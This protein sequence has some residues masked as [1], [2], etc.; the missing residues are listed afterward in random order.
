MD[1]ILREM[2]LLESQI[3]Y[4]AKKYYDEDAPEISDYDYDM[5]FERLKA[6]ELAY[7][8]YASLSS[9]TRRVGGHV[10]KR[11]E[12]AVHPVRMGSLADVFNDEGVLDF[13]NRVS[14]RFPETDYAVECKIDGLSVALEY[15]DGVLTK[16]VTRG[17]GFT[18]EIVT[19]NMKTIRS[20]P[21]TLK[22][23]L[24]RL[25][26]RGE[27]YMPKKV[28][29][30]LNAGREADGLSPFAN[31]RNAAAGSLRQLDSKL[32][33]ERRLSV[34]IFNVQ[35]CET[36]LPETHGET[37]KYMES[38]G[39]VVSPEFEICKNYHE[40]ADK[41]TRIGETR[42]D[43]PFEIDGAVVKVNALRLRDIM[44]DIGAVP[45][46]AVAFKYP[47][48][49]AET[50][51][52]DIVTQVGRTGVLT[53]KA[54]LKPV[55]VAG[56]VVAAATL[57]N[58]DYI[59]EKDIR[60]GDA[61]T[62]RKAGD[63]IPE[64]LRVIKEKRPADAA[65]FI[66]PESCPS[67]G[68]KVIREDGESATRCTNSACPAQLLRNIVHFVS[69]NAMDIETLGEK[70]AE[71]F[72][73]EGL[74]K[75]VADIYTLQKRQIA[76]LPGMGEKSAENLEN[77]IKSAAS[78]PLSK[79][80]YALGIRHVGEKA[81]KTLAKR[82]INI[83]DLVAAGEETLVQIDEIGPETAKS[84]V[85]FFSL[86]ENLHVIEKLAAL[87][88]NL[89]EPQD[90]TAE[91]GGVFDGMTVVVTGKLRDLSREEAHALIEKNGGKTAASVSGRT[92]LLVCGADAGSKLDKAQN[93]GIRVMDE[94]E[95][96]NMEGL[97][98]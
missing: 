60:V 58:A 71:K 76:S 32:C 98:K 36:P 90:E 37:L 75:S 41:I 97:K 33:A 2:R 35:L 88:V 85:H 20:A 50:T 3:E 7:P 47:P 27:V 68:E 81:A 91:T 64:I 5:L 69:R 1:A 22:E 19:E 92:S 83:E 44:G 82:F 39:F 62:V 80:I 9:P 13:Y 79:L 61:V 84:I 66:M 28:F 38:L 89:T 8:G 86:P 23:K 16:G 18:G 57:H 49:N 63:I 87:G 67:C 11:F 94:N 48:E 29:A 4:H 12:K 65:P 55:T 56:S 46:W 21:L 30:A 10:A 73:G 72:I 42:R 14:A 95:F 31:P 45:R 34:F 59:A 26:V 74:I 70:A 6:L 78:R 24:P 53:P 96:L 52:L 51:V 25:I 54:I 40:I 17:D 77:A 43:F 15:T 93:L